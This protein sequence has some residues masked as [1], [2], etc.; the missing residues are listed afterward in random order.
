MKPKLN[1]KEK[2]FMKKYMF[3]LTLCIAQNMHTMQNQNIENHM[4]KF[5]NKYAL[6]LE[7]QKKL[8]QQNMHTIDLI[9]ENLEMV[10][11]FHKQQLTET[12]IWETKDILAAI[13][14]QKFPDHYF[15]YC[16]GEFQSDFNTNP[17]VQLMVYMSNLDWDIEIAIQ[18]SC[19]ST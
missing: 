5:H 2:E 8:R 9:S 14:K 12:T 7:G 11:N 17:Y 6:F 4:Q 13:F 19:I 16:T 1:K 15:D 10:K 18:K 3:L